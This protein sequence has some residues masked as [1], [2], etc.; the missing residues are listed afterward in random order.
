MIS[1]DR[2]LCEFLSQYVCGGGYVG[3]MS[4]SAS[5]EL[6]ALEVGCMDEYGDEWRCYLSLHPDNA[7]YDHQWILVIYCYKYVD[8]LGYVYSHSMD[9]RFTASVRYHPGLIGKTAPDPAYH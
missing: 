4:W 1:R 2:G 7:L 5:R 3:H 9:L 8:P 6:D